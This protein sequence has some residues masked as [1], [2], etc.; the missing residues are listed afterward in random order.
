MSD[1]ISRSKLINALKVHFDSCFIEDGKLLY[2]EHICTSDDVVD[3][4]NLVENQPTAYDIDKVVADLE[5][6]ASR[7]TKKYT[8]PYGNNGYKD[9]KAISIHKAIEI[10]KQGGVSDDVC[11]WHKVKNGNAYKCNTH[12]EIHDS[13]VLDWCKCPYCGKKI[14]VVE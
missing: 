10:V 2:S 5:K 12:A 1:L 4:I 9:T 14:K 6:N 11:E 13:R 7:Y 3:L 8:T